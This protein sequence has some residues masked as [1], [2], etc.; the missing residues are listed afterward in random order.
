[1]A[2]RADDVVAMVRAI[3][4][5]AALV[6]L[7]VYGQSVV[8]PQ[9][10]VASVKLSG[11]DP[12]SSSGMYTGHGRLDAHN[13]TLKRCIIGAYGVGP[14]EISGG[15]NW[16]DTDRFDILAKAD[17]PINDD[18]VLMLMLQGLLAERFQLA[19]RRE[20]RTIP[21]LV[22]EV[23]KNGPK[24]EKADAGDVPSTTT[25]T[26]NSGAKI[27][28]RHTDLDSF[29]KILARQMSLPVLNQTGLSGIFNFKLHW[30]PDDA[31]LAAGRDTEG[32]S[33]FTAI[34]EQLGLRLRSA[35]APVTVLI[36]AHAERPTE[37]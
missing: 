10:E 9:F 29:A 1:V 19:I 21:A 37:N 6:G 8:A 36:I 3:P 23:A 27:G 28:A 5:L 32:P 17:Q 24:L 34:Q 31:R 12:N 15:P 20:T 30:T 13:V 25:S 14:H 35:K 16:L 26:N 2:Y 33:I 18:A 7:T 11:A 4:S 22:L